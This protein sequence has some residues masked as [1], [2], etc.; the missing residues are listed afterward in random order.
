M[1]DEEPTVPCRLCRAPTPML[2]TKLCDH[3]W[4][5]ERR[6]QQAPKIA[7]R[8]LRRV[9]K[10]MRLYVWTGFSPDYTGGLAVAIATS[11][12]AARRAVIKHRGFS[13]SEW[14][15]LSVH[16]VNKPFVETV[17]GGG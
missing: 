2:G 15:T 11:E 12:K 9:E 6:V 14:G 17:S 5:L 3:C 7:A 13:P 10:P 4:E 16:P 8:V 1:S